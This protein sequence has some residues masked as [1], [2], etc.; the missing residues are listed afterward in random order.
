MRG[1][2]HAKSVK[3]KMVT[4]ETQKKLPMRILFAILISICQLEA[5]DR[6]KE[7][8]LMKSS[9]QIEREGQKEN[10]VSFDF[11]LRVLYTQISGILF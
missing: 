8:W 5:N 3:N 10:D 11:V 7:S 1:K 4:E 2:S 6:G 9:F